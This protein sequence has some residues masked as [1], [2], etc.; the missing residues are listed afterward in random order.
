MPTLAMTISHE[1][2]SL[3]ACEHDAQ[4]RHAR[5]KL[6]ALHAENRVMKENIRQLLRE[7][8]RL[9]YLAKTYLVLEPTA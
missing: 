8:T 5:L 7:V 3:N 9:E 6:A 1:D 4:L 2:D